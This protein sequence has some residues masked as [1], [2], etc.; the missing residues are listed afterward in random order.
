MS[1]LKTFFAN[2]RAMAWPK[3]ERTEKEKSETKIPK[4]VKME[5]G[6]EDKPKTPLQI[7]QERIVRERIKK[8]EE[9]SEVL[10][11]GY[12]ERLNE[13]LNT[14]FSNFSEDQET[15]EFAYNLIDKEWKQYCLKANASQ[16][17]LRLKPESFEVEV[18]RIISEN[19]QF[20]LKEA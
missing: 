7:A 5:T 9:K 20:Q 1:K 8:Y 15:N 16:N 4:V 13:H 19:P 6:L 11:K 12:T 14:Y 2:I 3:D 18:K 10:G 17:L